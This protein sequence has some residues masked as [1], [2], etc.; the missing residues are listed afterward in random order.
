MTLQWGP[1]GKNLPSITSYLDQ[2]KSLC[3][4]RAIEAK[5]AAEKPNGISDNELA[6]G[7]ALYLSAKTEVNGYITFLQTAA[8]RRFREKDDAEQ[9][10]KRLKRADKEV[11]AFLAWADEVMKSQVGAADPLAALLEQLQNVLQRIQEG[12]QKMI[13]QLKE[14]LE[15]CRFRDWS[16]LRPQTP[17]GSR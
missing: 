17:T 15:K 16:E 1:G 4:G 11:N 14:A 2:A 7:R 5:E 3:E 9:V 12:D 13:D 8:A 6:K 10:E